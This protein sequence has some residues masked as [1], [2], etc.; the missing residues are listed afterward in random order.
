MPLQPTYLTLTPT[1]A[2]KGMTVTGGAPAVWEKV[3]LRVVGAATVEGGIPDGFIVR[4]IPVGHTC[5]A[6]PPWHA[7]VAAVP[8]PVEYAR[9]PL[10]ADDVWTVD[11]AD[12]TAVLELGTE[13]LEAVF[14]GTPAD[15]QVEVRIVAE[16]ASAD[17]LYAMGRLII[18][19]WLQDGADPVAGSSALKLRVDALETGMEA[20]TA[21]RVAADEDEAEARAEA[22]LLLANAVAGKADSVALLQE[23]ADRTAVVQ[24]EADARVAAD[25]GLANAIAAKADAGALAAETSNRVAA[26]AQEAGIRAA[27]DVGLQADINTRATVTALGAEASARAA[28]DNA[29]Q[30]EINNR[31]VAP[32][33]GALATLAALTDLPPSFTEEDTRLVL[34]ALQAA[35]KGLYA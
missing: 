24:A 7:A 26:D 31:Q 35:V 25:A 5:G 10:A 32:S 11:G 33:A 27:A 2:N 21:A 29:L 1:W 8:T 12:L 22:D 3:N 34:N 13:A 15:S 20:E 30:A 28:A 18:R 19:N 6:L 23:I 4:V 17:N 14:G 16:S 9:F